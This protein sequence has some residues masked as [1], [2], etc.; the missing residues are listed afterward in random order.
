[1]P[2]FLFNEILFGPVKSRRLGNSLGINL[3]PIESKFCN[4]DCVYCECGWTHNANRPSLPDRTL[5]ALELEKKLKEIEAQGIRCDVITFAGN[6]E[7]TIHPQFLEIMIDTIAIRDKMCPGTDIAVLTNATMLH[8]QKVVDALKMADKSFM[9]I[10]SAISETLHLIN[11]PIIPIVIDDLASKM[12]TFG[13]KLIIQ[14]LF[15]RGEIEKK[16]IDN[17]TDIEIAAL[18]DFYKKAEPSVVHIYSIDRDTPLNTLTKIEKNEL[19]E[20]AQKIAAHGI[21]IH[22]Y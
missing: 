6:G 14:T 2:T 18:I 16:H 11:K 3:L 19:S 5:I 9:K 15:L 12:K 20:I 8:N 1:M 7:P 17:T 22:V 21:S 13:T 4:F 10:D